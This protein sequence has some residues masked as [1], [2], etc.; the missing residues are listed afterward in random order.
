MNGENFENMR[1]TARVLTLY[2]EQG[3]NQSQVAAELGLSTAKVNRLIKQA[4]DQGL[5]EIKIHTPFATAFDL[6]DRLKSSFGVQDAVIVPQVS[7]DPAAQMTA[8]GRAGA[9]RLLQ[10]LRDGD[11]ICISGG[12]AVYEVV[13][14]TEPK[15]KFDVVVVPATGGVQGLYHTDVNFLAS[16]LAGRLGG[17]AYQ[18][19][20][21]IFVDSAE[22]KRALLAMRQIGEVIDRARSADI[23][24][25]GVGGVIPGTSSFFDLLS[26]SDSERDRIIENE[27]ARGDLF[28][29]LFDENGQ[30]CAPDLSD[31]LIGVDIGDVRKVPLSIGVA[32]GGQKVKPLSGVLRGG[33][34]KALVTDEPTASSVLDLQTTTK[35]LAKGEVAR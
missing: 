32:A 9:T 29:H 14:A 1:L 15:A 10:S 2:Y 8:I 20:A 21:P 3:R 7:D 13:K 27:A 28:G 18:L 6:E 11:V 22:E 35:A 31:R 24:L 30:S 26:S 19:H 17:R 33:Y 25:V 12:K 4:K 34:L 16:E 5:V 23:A